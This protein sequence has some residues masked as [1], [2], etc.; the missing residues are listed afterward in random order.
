[1]KYPHLHNTPYVPS[2]EVKEKCKIKKKP[3]M[4]IPGT[5]G[6]TFKLKLQSKWYAKGDTLI[7]DIVRFKNLFLRFWGFYISYSAIIIS[8]PIETETSVEYE[9][10]MF[11]KHYYIL[12]W[13]VLT[14]K[15]K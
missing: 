2:R 9:L 15:T 14:L 4:N 7:V 5:W 3:K 13:N 1:M 8:D 11:K 6:E 10:K 12:G